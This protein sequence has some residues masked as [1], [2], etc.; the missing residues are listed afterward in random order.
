M[1]IYTSTQGHSCIQKAVELLGFGSDYL[2]KIPVDADYRI[3]VAAL[4]SADRRRPRRWAASGLRRRQRR[5]GQH[6]RD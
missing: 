5:D 3:D 1:V 6:R 2:R 4:E